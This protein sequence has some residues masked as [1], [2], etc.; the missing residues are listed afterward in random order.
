MPAI[1]TDL[2]KKNFTTT[3][4]TVSAEVRAF[5]QHISPDH[6]PT[7]VPV[8]PDAG[9]LPSECFNNVASKVERDGGTLVYGW[10]IWEWPRVFVEAEHH[11]VWEQ[12]GVLTDI[13][14]YVNDERQIL[15]LPDPTRTYDFITQK[16]LINIKKNLGKLTSVDDWIAAADRLH[17]AI[18]TNSIGNHFMLERSYLASMD[19]EIRNALGLVFVD[20]AK[21]TGPNSQCFCASGRKFKK[22]CGPLIQLHP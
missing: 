5:C 18:K 10:L 17:R 8:S 13:T 11:A 4:K 22:C 16:R 1:S 7:Y 9:A 21:S 2:F 6:E 14:P 20:L 15:F 3:P 12:D 19:Q